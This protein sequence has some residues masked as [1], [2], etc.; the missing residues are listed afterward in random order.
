MHFR[1]LPL[2]RAYVVDWV[3]GII[4]GVNEMKRNWVYG[5]TATLITAVIAL[6]PYGV[7]ANESGIE[8]N[9]NSIPD[10]D[11]RRCVSEYDLNADGELSNEEIAVVKEINVRGY[12]IVD[13]T[14]IEFL[15]RSSH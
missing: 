12:D 14:G 5:F 3:Y 1:V 7:C 9:E 2:D 11:F 4:E 10:T 13:L 8:I 6:I 15:R